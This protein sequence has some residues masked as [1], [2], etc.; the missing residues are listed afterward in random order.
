MPNK[1]WILFSIV[2]LTGCR[3]AQD[4]PDPNLPVTPAQTAKLLAGH[5]IEDSVNLEYF[6]TIPCVPPAY[7]TVDS[8]LSYSML[9]TTIFNNP[10]NPSIDDDTGQFIE[11]GSRYIT[12]SSVGGRH[13]LGEFG[14]LQINK[15]TEHEL[16]LFS[17]LHVD[18]PPTWYFHK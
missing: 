7:L 8:D 6:T 18:S 15:L 2:L 17:I 9:Q 11:I 4:P 16:V 12:A 14:K 10:A 13:Y 1:T 3:K 5:W